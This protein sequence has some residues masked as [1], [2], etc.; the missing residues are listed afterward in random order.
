MNLT[1][2]LLHRSDWN[3][4]MSVLDLFTEGLMTGSSPSHRIF[5]PFIFMFAVIAMNAG[6]P[7]PIFLKKDTSTAI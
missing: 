3:R 5:A 1:N 4:K 2:I 7:L 6:L